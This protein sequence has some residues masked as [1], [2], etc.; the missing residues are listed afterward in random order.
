[1]K[2][3]FWLWALLVSIVLAWCNSNQNWGSNYKWELVVQWVGPEI[4]MESTVEEWTLVLRWSFEDHTDHIFLKAWTREDQFNSESEYLPWNTVK[5]KWY[6][7]PLDWAAWNHYYDVVNIESLKVSGYPNVQGIKD[8]LDSYSYCEQDSDCTYIAWSCPFWCYIAFNKK[9]W[10]IPSYILR[11]YFDLN[12]VECVYDCLNT[13]SVICENYKCTMTYDENID[14][15][16]VMCDETS[17]AEDTMCIMIYDPVCGSDGN[18]YWNS[19]EACKSE[20]VISYTQW[21][22]IE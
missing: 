12:D 18:T 10:D 1:M 6:V 19:C 8:I 11:Q 2:K 3:T 16:E 7:T 4:S 20:N 5:F 9:F 22:C 13:N 17:K 21:E 15:E 14:E